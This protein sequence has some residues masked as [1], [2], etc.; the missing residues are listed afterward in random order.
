M[1]ELMYVLENDKMSS[2]HERFWV[3]EYMFQGEVY[4]A[5]TRY[6]WEAKIFKR[7][8]KNRDNYY[9]VSFSPRLLTDKERHDVVGFE[10]CKTFGRFL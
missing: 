10:R 3:S 9:G 7:K 1:T 8:P 5:T 4:P 6:V 2:A